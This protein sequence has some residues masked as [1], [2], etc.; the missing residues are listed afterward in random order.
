MPDS[1]AHPLLIACLAAL[2][3]AGHAGCNRETVEPAAPR[4]ESA[5]AV[6][7]QASVPRIMRGTIG[8]ETVL[9]GYDRS[10]S[11]RYQP[12]L[13]W[14]YGLA[15]GL[16]GTGSTNLPPALRAHMLAEMGKRGIGS[17]RAGW[18]HLRP[19]AM[20]DSRDTAVVIVEAVVPQGAQEDTHFDIRVTADPRTGT[21]SLEGGRLYTTELR[22]RMG[23]EL[24]PPVGGGQAFALAEASGTI[25]INPFAEPGALDRDSINRTSGRILNGGVVV[26]DMPLKLRLAQPSH[27]RASI[28]Q[29]AINARFPEEPGQRKQTA[30]GES[31]ESI[32]LTVP[33][34]FLGRTDEFVELVI[35]T[36]I[37]QTGVEGVAASIRRLVVANPTF[38]RAASWRWQA[39][40]TRSI[41]VI[42]E[43]YD[44]PEA[45]PR[46][47]SLRAGARLGDATVVPHLIDMSRTASPEN[48]REAIDLLAGMPVDPRIDES[49]RGLLDDDDTET[50]LRAYE[51]LAERGDPYLRRAAVDGK[52][53]LDVVDSERPLI[54]IAQ[55]GQ[56]RIV[57]FGRDLELERPIT[58]QAWS[59][60]LIVKGDVEEDL[61][62]VYYRQTEADAGVINQVE[63]RLEPFV[64]FLG[65][66]TTVEHPRI[67]LGLSYGETVG[68]IHQIWS[69]DYIDA[70]FKAEQDRILAA[71]IRAQR[72]AVVTERPEFG[73]PPPDSEEDTS[74]PLFGEP[75]DE[76]PEAGGGGP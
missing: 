32:E 69:Q 39:L 21:T 61:V 2:L 9:L 65:H 56:P 67:G 42:R 29:S 66:T 11:R 44:H 71:I 25:F 8:A 53:L 3:A 59:N 30:W 36:T 38:A 6:N 52:F 23:G 35:H 68:A 62:E 37:R 70:D 55:A 51:A 49:L 31:G 19:E 1:P 34:S 28:I 48:R 60:R 46:L 54:Y 57:L 12:V 73:E 10:T 24:L 43:L 26:K 41:P 22:P 76:A 4:P 72:E 7:F 27:T 74:R 18:G 40:G 15:V 14:G 17:E 63:P 16:K 64:Q 45:L 47:S 50:R 58:M 75:E 20:L 5:R 33:P 13:V